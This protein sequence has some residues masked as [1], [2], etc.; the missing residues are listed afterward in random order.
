MYILWGLILHEA[1]Q[2]IGRIHLLILLSTTKAN[3]DTSFHRRHLQRFQAGL[4]HLAL[5]IYFY[6]YVPYVIYLHVCVTR[7]WAIARKL[8]SLLFVSNIVDCD[9]FQVLLYCEDCIYLWL[10]VCYMQLI[11]ISQMLDLLEKFFAIGIDMQML[12]N[13]GCLWDSYMVPNLTLTVTAW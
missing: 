11:W 7:A 2:K 6:G 9:S 5:F 3:W 8:L 12:F 13:L 10:V 4:R 1:E